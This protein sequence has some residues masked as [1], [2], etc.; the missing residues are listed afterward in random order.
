KKALEVLSR[1]EARFPSDAGVMSAIADLYQRWGK[2][3]LAIAEYER[4]AKLEPDDPSHLV[5]LGEQYWAK[6]DKP[7]ALATG[8][9]IIANGKA[10]SYAKLGEVMLEHNF[11]ADAL[12]DYDKAIKLDGKN[13]EF[14]KGLAAVYESQ[15]NFDA[16]IAE[17]DKVLGLIGNKVTDRL[18]R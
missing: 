6:Q 18:A 12:A 7:R 14:H 17:W 11:P 13:P 9:K 1:L 3:D 5:T 4:L 10:T 8:K 16:A 15:K 2:E